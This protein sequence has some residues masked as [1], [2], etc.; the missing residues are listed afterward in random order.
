MSNPQAGKAWRRAS[1]THLP[2][3][4]GVDSS[5]RLG[6][7]AAF[8]ATQFWTDQLPFYEGQNGY[9]KLN[10]P[11][12]RMYTH[13]FF[14][15]TPPG[16]APGPPVNTGARV[17]HFRGCNYSLSPATLLPYSCAIF[18]R[19]FSKIPHFLQAHLFLLILPFFLGY[20]RHFRMGVSSRVISF[21]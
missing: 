12:T 3:G 9:S 4:R 16:A 10:P 15:A 7:R 6:K 5:T 14:E 20:Q 1:Q 8:R 18:L 19:G 21:K 13:P 11:C 17:R 2:L